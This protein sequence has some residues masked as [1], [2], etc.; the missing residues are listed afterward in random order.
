MPGSSGAVSGQ[1]SITRGESA[2]I[3]GETLQRVVIKT[4]ELKMCAALILVTDR[5]LFESK[6]NTPTAISA[7]S[8]A[9]SIFTQLKGYL[10]AIVPVKPLIT[11]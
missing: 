2:A 11:T 3:A 1:R 7:A 4:T 9:N 8:T 6:M 5:Y 10:P